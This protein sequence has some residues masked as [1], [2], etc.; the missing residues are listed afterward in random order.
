MS[1]REEHKKRKFLKKLLNKYR[2]TILNENKKE[3]NAHRF[4]IRPLS[5]LMTLFFLFA[6]VVI[7]LYLIVVYTPVGTLIPGYIN[8]R[9]KEELISSNIRIDSITYEMAKQE[10]YIANIKAIL[11][12]DITLDSIKNSPQHIT[13]DSI[14]IESSELEKE[15]MKEWEERERYNLTSQA[16]NV[17]EI[18]SLNLFRPAQGEIIR[19][20]DI[21]S[22]HYGVDI[23]EVPGESIRAVHDGTVVMSDFTANDGYTIV[24][25]HRE[26]MISVYRNCY[27]LMKNIGDKVTKGEAIGTFSNRKAE[28]NKKKQSFLHLE[29]WHRGKPLD[30]NTYIAF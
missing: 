3:E 25:Q 27:R 12:G 2:F 29:L 21:N 6:L 17:N 5:V 16:T 26:N 14:D 11:N 15:F 7:V 8:K 30:P 10:R 18:Q 22:G 4:S 23:A 9:T 19:A 24:I 28:E 20:F 13:S 1:K